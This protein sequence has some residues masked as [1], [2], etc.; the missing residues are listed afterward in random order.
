MK[1]SWRRIARLGILAWVLTSC[2]APP[3]STPDATGATWGAALW[4][5]ATWNP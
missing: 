5:D 4:N 2:G 3:T 1:R